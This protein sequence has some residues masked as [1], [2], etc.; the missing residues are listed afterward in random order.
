M[1]KRV[2]EIVTE[3]GRVWVRVLGRN[4]KVSSSSWKPT[5]HGILNVM[6]FCTRC[7]IELTDD[8]IQACYEIARERTL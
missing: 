3:R 1:R 4:S 6:A 8:S 5:T 2:A 7:D